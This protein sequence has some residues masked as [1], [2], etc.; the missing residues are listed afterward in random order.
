MGS[1]LPSITAKTLLR[2]LKKRGFEENRQKGSHLTL[3]N[4]ITRKTITIPIHTGIDIGKG[5]LKKILSDAGF[6]AEDFNKLR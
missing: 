4:H 5:L 3:I 2:F 1:K 6:T